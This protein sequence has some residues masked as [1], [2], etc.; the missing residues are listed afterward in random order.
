MAKTSMAQMRATIK[1]RNN[2]YDRIELNV[3]KG[4]K[5]EYKKAAEAQGI[6][7]MELARRGIEE[8]IANHSAVDVK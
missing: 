8:Y 5:E 4:K 2:N 3:K 6:G 7:L 1:Y